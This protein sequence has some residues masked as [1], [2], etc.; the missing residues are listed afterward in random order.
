MFQCVVLLVWLS[1]FVEFVIGKG[2]VPIEIMCVLDV[3]EQIRCL[4]TLGLDPTM[5]LG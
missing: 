1:R 2:I 3:D 5:I 4:R